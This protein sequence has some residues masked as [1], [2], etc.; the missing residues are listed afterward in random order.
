MRSFGQE[1]Q[2][3]VAR[4]I[5]FFFWTHLGG[6]IKCYR[7]QISSNQTACRTTD[8]WP[9]IVMITNGANLSSTAGS[10]TDN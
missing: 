6:K 8:P 4:V 7:N 1:L 9:F 5:V 2:N 10:L 3:C